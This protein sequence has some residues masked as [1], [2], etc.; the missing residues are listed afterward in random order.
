MA[1]VSATTLWIFIVVLADSAGAG[2]NN[3]GYVGHHTTLNGGFGLAITQALVTRC[4]Q[5][6]Q[7]A[8]LASL[9]PMSY[10]SEAKSPK[11]S[12]NGTAASSFGKDLLGKGFDRPCF[13]ALNQLGA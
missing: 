8:S 5:S 11:D 4:N 13:Q 3:A 2:A 6:P 12:V 7:I 1:A 9:F 10:G